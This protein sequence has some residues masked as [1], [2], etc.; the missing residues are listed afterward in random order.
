MN[1]NS[2]E[3]NNGGTKIRNF[4]YRELNL[5]NS[6]S[7]VNMGIFSKIFRKSQNFPKIPK[8]PSIVLVIPVPRFLQLY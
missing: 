1:Q 3:R 6:G 4:L 2:G 7:F 8:F 5:L